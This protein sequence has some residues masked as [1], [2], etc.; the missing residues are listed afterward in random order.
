MLNLGS[1]SYKHGPGNDL[2]MVATPTNVTPSNSTSP[3]AM[4]SIKMKE[5]VSQSTSIYEM[6]VKHEN[7]AGN[8]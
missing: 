4:P 6:H 7:G 5:E 2:L 1:P 3:S 8:G